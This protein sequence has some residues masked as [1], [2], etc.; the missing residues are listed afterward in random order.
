MGP[1]S[2][3]TGPAALCTLN[4]IKRCSPFGRVTAESIREHCCT[5]IFLFPTNS[6][7][8]FY[9]QHDHE[10]CIIEFCTPVTSLYI[11]WRNIIGIITAT[12][13]IYFGSQPYNG[14]KPSGSTKPVARFYGLSGKYIFKGQDLSFYYMGLKL[15]F[16]GTRF[17]GE[18]KNLGGI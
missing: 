6:L 9:E 15:Y 16:M 3:R 4:I 13:G 8:H 12:S 18:E 1:A 5:Q 10:H 17:W 14:A 11:R 2:A 7:A